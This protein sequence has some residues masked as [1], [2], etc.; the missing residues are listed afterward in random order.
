M[1]ELPKTK[2]WG[3]AQLRWLELPKGEPEAY[4]ASAEFKF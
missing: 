3:S 2:N 1:A 4:S